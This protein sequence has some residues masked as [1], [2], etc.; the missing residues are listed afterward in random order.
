MNARP[1]RR[2]LA[3]FC[4]FI[5]TLI[6]I[7]LVNPHSL[8]LYV[9]YFG[10]WFVFIYTFHREVINDFRFAFILNSAWIGAYYLVQTNVFPESYGTTS[11]LG[12]QSD[13]SYFFSLVADS[14]PYK[15]EVRNEYNLYNHPFTSAIRHLTILTIDH[16]MDVIFFQSGVAATLATFSKRFMYQI[17]SDKHLAQVVYA[18]ALVCP[19]LMMNGGVV[20]LRDTF[21]AALLIY[22]LSCLNESRYFLALAAVAI[23]IAI[24]PGTGLIL[25]PIYFVIY[26]EE[27]KTW[28][29]QHIIFTISGLIVLSGA[30]WFLIQTALANASELLMGTS[31]GG[32]VSLLGREIFDGLTTAADGNKILLAIQEQTFVIKLILNGAYIFLYPFLSPKFAFSGNSFDVRS[33]VLNFV[34]P[35]YSFWLNAWFTAGVLNRIKVTK[36]QTEVVISIVL[37]F[38]LIGTYSIQSRHKTIIYPLYYIVA[39][40][41]FMRASK[42]SLQIG[43]I[44]SFSLIAMQV[45]LI[46]R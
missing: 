1:I 5:F 3:G 36:R 12:S 41:G 31:E 17:S 35:I 28:I 46:I 27:I 18:F 6:S 26:F 33:V 20:F 34:F 15:L 9:Y 40:I 19:F 29:N 32:A 16:P 10:L 43:Y 7:V 30:I 39:A 22:S 38:L 25:L 45:F 2:T 37:F 4:A 23:Q 8:A 24:R 11:P 21:S 42:L 13:D 14:I 44:F